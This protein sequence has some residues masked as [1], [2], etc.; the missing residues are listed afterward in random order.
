LDGDKFTVQTVPLDD[1]MKDFTDKYPLPERDLNPN[2]NGIRD[3]RPLGSTLHVTKQ[4]RG[5][6]VVYTA[7]GVSGEPLVS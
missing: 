3:A 1:N 6:T 7:N 4:Y 5:L 2:L